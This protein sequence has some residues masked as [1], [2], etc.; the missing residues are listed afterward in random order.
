MNISLTDKFIKDYIGE[1]CGWDHPTCKHQQITNIEL[2]LLDNN[3][4]WKVLKNGKIEIWP[5]KIEGNYV[6][7]GYH[8]FSLSS[9]MND[10]LERVECDM[11]KSRGMGN[12]G[13]LRVSRSIIKSIK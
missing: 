3:L 6:Y 10:N 12:K 11:E 4:K 13:K 1:K 8:V 2:V 9:M 7:I 5:F